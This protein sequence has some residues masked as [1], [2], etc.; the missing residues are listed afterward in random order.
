M[1]YI[2]F[3]FLFPLSLL[4]QEDSPWRPKSN[5][6]IGIGF[7]GEKLPEGTTYYPQNILA[8]FYVHHFSK[9][10]GGLSLYGE[11][12]FVPAFLSGSDQV[13]F[14]YGLNAGFAYHGRISNQLYWQAAIG[15]SYAVEGSSHFLFLNSGQNWRPYRTEQREY[16]YSRG[17]TPGNEPSSLQDF[18][19]PMIFLTVPEGRKPIARDKSPGKIKAYFP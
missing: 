6:A 9:K 16:F 11:P 10:P 8:R 3:L 12:Q 5:L 7:I 17:F 18:M 2:L 19:R 13:E 1:K 4:A 15:R 14:E